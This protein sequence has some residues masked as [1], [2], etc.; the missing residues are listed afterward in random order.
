MPR[1]FDNITQSLL[2]A[3]SE[4]LQVADHAD[5]CVGYFNIRGWKTI[6]FHIDKWSGGSGHCCRLLVG[7]QRLPQDELQD[8]ISI[9]K[10][11]A[12]IDNQTALRLK[13]KLAEEFRRQLT[14]VTYGDRFHL[15]DSLLTTFPVIPMMTTNTQLLKLGRQLMAN[16][17]KGAE[18]K[19]IQTKDGYKIAY[20]E[21]FGWKSKDTIDKIDCLLA[22]HYGLTDEENDFSVNFDIKYRMGQDDGDD[23]DE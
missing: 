13:K 16:L 8:A 3:L 10:N 18:R 15:S 23:G 4:T 5:F 12:G 6:D 17:R 22:R 2:P 1:I 19:T 11:D 20:D 7:M 9:I 14:P 21:Y